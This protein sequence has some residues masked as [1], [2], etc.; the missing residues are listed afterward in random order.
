MPAL[1][2]IPFANCA[3]VA[4][5]GLLASQ[6]VLLTNGVRKGSAFSGTDLSDIADIFANWL[7]NDLDPLLSDDLEWDYVK[8]TDLTTQFS[9]VFV[10]GTGLPDNGDVTGVPVPNNVAAVISFQTGN[11]GRSFRGRNYI[12]AAPSSVLQTTSQFTT[13][14]AA[15]IAAA[16]GALAAALGTAGFDHVVLSRYENSVRRTTG[17]ATRITAY[18][19]KTPVGTQ[20]RRVIG[21]GI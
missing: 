18:N 9:P 8:V 2:F 3:E 14:F 12:P 10:G 6:T 1:P 19:A 17:V 5:F 13:A 16:Y 11:R 15:N 21:V 4:C 7:V 20:R